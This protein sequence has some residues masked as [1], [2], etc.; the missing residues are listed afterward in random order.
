LASQLW[1][2]E[3]RGIFLQVLSSCLRNCLASRYSWVNNT[4]L[5]L[6]RHLF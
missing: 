1:S 4:G 5:G 2:I 6:V 3:M